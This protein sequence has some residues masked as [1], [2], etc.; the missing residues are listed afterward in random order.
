MLTGIQDNLLL[1]MV[2]SL[3]AGLST[4][5]GA[6]LALFVK[7][8]DT[9]ML[10]FALGTSAGVMVYISFMELMP[11]AAGMLTD[12][13]KLVTTLAF[14]GGMAL[15]CVIDRLIPE[16]ENPHEIP[17]P[18]SMDAVKATGE[19][20]GNAK[21]RRS[22]LLFTLAIA[23]HNFPEGIAT[24]ASAFDNTGIATSVALAVAI[25]NVPEGIAV[26]LPLLYGTGDRRKAF[27]WA[28]L[29][30]LAE[31]LGAMIGMLL[32]LPFLSPT[33]LA[34]LFA[35]VAGIMV[36]ISFDELLPM[37]ERWGHHHLSIYGVAAGMLIMALV[38]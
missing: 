31:P 6:A 3:L 16:D 14:F 38:L 28:T 21:L 34:V 29:S 17:D 26:A 12:N 10:T 27:G 15:A 20:A 5:I 32:L 1:G 19:F 35:V 2:L 36:Y 30:G 11:A 22:A 18:G 8:T 25:H 7:R 9:R 24:V 23:I 13:V 33:L 37:A 4:G